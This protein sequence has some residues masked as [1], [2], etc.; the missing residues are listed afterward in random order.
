MFHTLSATVLARIFS[1][2]KT[3]LI[4]EKGRNW[5]IGRL[6]EFFSWL[7][8]NWRTGNLA[9]SWADIQVVVLKITFWEV[10]MRV[11]ACAILKSHKEARRPRTK[12]VWWTRNESVGGG[13]LWMHWNNSRN[14]LPR[15]EP[16]RFPT[17]IISGAFRCVQQTFS[18]I[19][20]RLTEMTK[21]MLIFMSLAGDGQ[22]PSLTGSFSLVEV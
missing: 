9:L 19:W 14:T 13:L 3:I 2:H 7:K 1:I 18:F 8:N 5:L 15:M 10:S 11:S 16:V 21:K 17:G 4:T 20:K 6:L 22:S 12:Y